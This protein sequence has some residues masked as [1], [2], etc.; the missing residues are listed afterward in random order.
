MY[1][2]KTYCKLCCIKQRSIWNAFQE[3]AKEQDWREAHTKDNLELIPTE[4]DDSISS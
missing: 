3:A 2:H 1:I 4:F